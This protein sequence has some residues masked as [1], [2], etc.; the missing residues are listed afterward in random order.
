MRWGTLEPRG[1]AEDK[2][3]VGTDFTLT[4]VVL[5][6]ETHATSVLPIFFLSPPASTFVAQKQTHHCSHFNV[7]PVLQ[8]D[9]PHNTPISP[10]VG[11]VLWFLTS[12]SCDVSLCYSCAMIHFYIV[13][14]R[15]TCLER[16]GDH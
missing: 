8:L 2:Q 4:D 7:T 1:A 12:L 16:V 9:A 13:L 10:P 15:P 6:L 14:E 3:K 11:E 5:D